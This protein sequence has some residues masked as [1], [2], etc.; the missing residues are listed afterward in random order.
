MMHQD[1]AVAYT[2]VAAGIASQADFST[3]MYEEVN[4]K[5]LHGVHI[6]AVKQVP[7]KTWKVQC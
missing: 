7:F 1:V 5:T 6:H 3:P 2:C 4:H